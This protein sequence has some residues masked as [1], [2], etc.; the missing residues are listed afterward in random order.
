MEAGAAVVGG[1]VVSGQRVAVHAGAVH[2]EV[3]LHLHRRCNTTTS[4]VRE[5]QHQRDAKNAQLFTRRGAVV[6]K[7]GV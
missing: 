7:K 4:D 1:D 6:V 5:P 3:L 2:V